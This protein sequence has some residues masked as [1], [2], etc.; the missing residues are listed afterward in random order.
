MVCLSVKAISLII[1][2]SLSLSLHHIIALYPPGK[3]GQVTSST[4][5]NLRNAYGKYLSNNAN[6][7]YSLNPELEQ[8]MKD[9]ATLKAGDETDNAG[10]CSALGVPPAN[11]SM[12]LLNY[13]LQPPEKVK[14]FCRKGKLLLY[15]R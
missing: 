12:A 4:F 7:E 6:L 10:K 5:T 9:V 11:G 3:D 14:E 8:I 1:N 15:T 13:F 2:L